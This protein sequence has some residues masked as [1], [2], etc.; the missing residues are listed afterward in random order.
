MN[1]GSLIQHFI[2]NVSKEN[3]INE[4]KTM[5]LALESNTFILFILTTTILYKISNKINLTDKNN[6]PKH[7]K[8][9]L[10]SSIISLIYL[11]ILSIRILSNLKLV[12]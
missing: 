1:L 4:Q 2:V 9:L 3:F 5:I 12:L 6:K 11:A 10:I 7:L 8:I